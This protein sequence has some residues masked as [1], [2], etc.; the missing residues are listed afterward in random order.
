V[1][2]EQREATKVGVEVLARGGNIGGGGFMLLRRHDG[3]ERFILPGRTRKRCC[4]AIALRA[5]G[6]S[7]REIPRWGCAQVVTV[8]SRTGWRYGGSDRRR[9]SGAAIGY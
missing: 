5:M 6:Y 3:F 7:L 4:T 1:A 8:D 2:T 9:P